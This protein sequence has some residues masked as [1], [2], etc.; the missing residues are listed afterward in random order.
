MMNKSFLAVTCTILCT[1]ALLSC[2][3]TK[4][5]TP[6]EKSAFVISETMMQRIALDTARE[7]PLSEIL[8]LNGH[9][10][11]DA[12]KKVEV[13]PFIGGTVTTVSAELG[14]VVRKGQVLAVI[15]SGDVAEYERQLIDA[16]SDVV[17]A[18][19]SLSVQRDLQQSRL[20][21]DRDVLAAQRELEKADA[22]LK[23]IHEI[24]RIY[25][26]NDRSEYLI[27]APISGF[28]VEKNVNAD[29]NLR[30]DRLQSMFTV[31]ELSEVLVLADVYETDISKVS[32]G[33]T[34]EITTLSYPDSVIVGVVDKVFSVLSPE[35]KTMSVRIKVANRDFRL[36]PGMVATVRLRF[37]KKGSMVAV[38]SSSIIFDASKNFVVVYRDRHNITVRE[39]R[40][41]STS[42]GKSFILNGVS[43]GDVVVCKNQ[44]FLYDALTD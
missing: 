18:Q 5:H 12:S 27:R 38:P 3:G 9:I 40:V 19:K 34:A 42:D 43:V 26:I 24:Y 14:D 23:R 6:K 33:M 31:A 20:S 7:Q 16:K 37:N 15:R 32:V 1:A 39:V 28:V 22:E 2:T 21:S 36:K 35:T 8:N 4:D 44:V 13:F 29:M 10:A 11:V 25:N 41:A 17:L 30:A